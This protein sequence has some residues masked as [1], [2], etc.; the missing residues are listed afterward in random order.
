MGSVSGLSEAHREQA[1]REIVRGV[2]MFMR[3]ID[4]IH[5]SQDAVLRWEGI[6]KH[7]SINRGQIPVHSD[8]SSSSAFLLWNALV[9]PYGVRDVVNGQLWRAGY[10]GTMLRHGKVVQHEKNLKIGDCALYGIP[11][12]TGKH[13][14][15]VI[16]RGADGR[17]RVFSHGSERGPF[18]LDLH[19]RDDLIECRRYI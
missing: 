8:C 1:R 3:N 6:N 15:V 9:L 18:I 4:A 14:A 10:T 5:Y 17:V 12:T 11:G 13:V 2:E 16:G 19:Y 7:M